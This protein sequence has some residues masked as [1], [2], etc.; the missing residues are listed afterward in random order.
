MACKFDFRPLTAGKINLL[1]NT[2]TSWT[3]I[4]IVDKNVAGTQLKMTDTTQQ[5][6]SSLP[7][8]SSDPQANP[9]DEKK[10]PSFDPERDIEP[11]ILAKLDPEWVTVFTEQ[12]NT[13]PPPPRHLLSMEYIR[14]H[15]EKFAPPFYL[16]TEG[17]PRT[18]EKE[19]ASEDGEKI[20]MRVYYPDEKVWGPGPYPVHL[21]FHGM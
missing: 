6:E 19:V 20:P 7:V 1:T 5:N 15:P 8:R 10:P 14:A 17:Y 13:N 18:A 16:D 11:H 9:S 21:N 4:H 12:M 2:T 3:T